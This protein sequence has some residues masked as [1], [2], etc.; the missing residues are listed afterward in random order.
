MCFQI[1]SNPMY[2]PIHLC[3][4]IFLNMPLQSNY[5]PTFT[6]QYISLSLSPTRGVW[7]QMIS[8]YTNP[9][10]LSQQYVAHQC[11]NCPNIFWFLS[12]R[13]RSFVQ[14]CLKI[15]SQTALDTHV[16]HTCR[17]VISFISRIL[18]QG[19]GLC[20]IWAEFRAFY[21]TLQCSFVYFR[22]EQ[23]SWQCLRSIHRIKADFGL[24]WVNL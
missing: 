2:F 10:Y 13:I 1:H 16:V 4:D 20:W 6:P 23:T 8:V 14:L 15:W 17:D 7:G 18:I 5:F 3:L 21:E 24:I 12:Q 11:Q 9:L 22:V 19:K